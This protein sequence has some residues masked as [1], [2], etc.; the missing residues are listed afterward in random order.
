MN[1]ASRHTS[2]CKFPILLSLLLTGATGSAQAASSFEYFNDYGTSSSDNAFG[3]NGGSGWTGA[4]TASGT[5]DNSFVGYTA[6]TQIGF[7]NPNYDGAGNDGGADDGRFT[8]SSSDNTS[9]I[10]FRD[11]S[12]EL[13][14]TIWVS[15]LVRHSSNTSGDALLWFDTEVSGVG[16]NSYVGLRSGDEVGLRYN[17]LNSSGA[18]MSSAGSNLLYIAKI[19]I[20]Y[21]GSFDSIDFWVKKEGDDLSSEL[22]L[23]ATSISA[24]GAD[25]YGSGLNS[26]GISGG[27]GGFSGY[28][29][30]RISNDPAAFDIVMTSVPE[31]GTT[32][33]LMGIAALGFVTLRRRRL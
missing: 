3:K 30:L 5:S 13:T 31:P 33:A 15:M 7:S 20:D 27:N 6:D 11:F 26:I 24:S 29:A 12:S 17:D 1:T 9:K 4:W 2:F 21:S 22:A 25:V 23:G 28:D 18:E 19:D 14:G 10:L 32:A 16:A 8:S